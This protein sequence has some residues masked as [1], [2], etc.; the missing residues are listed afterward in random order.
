[1]PSHTLNRPQE[2]ES[3]S[4]SVQSPESQGLTQPGCHRVPFGRRHRPALLW[5]AHGQGS[6]KNGEVWENDHW[7]LSGHKRAPRAPG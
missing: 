7:G 1:M 4:G 2:P 6:S 3:S 5:K